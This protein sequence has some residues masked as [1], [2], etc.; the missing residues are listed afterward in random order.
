[1]GADNDVMRN[2]LT[3]LWDTFSYRG[4]K[5]NIETL[6]ANP[7]FPVNRQNETF[8]LIY[9][10]ANSNYE[11]YFDPKHLISE[12]VFFRYIENRKPWY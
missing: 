8:E 7:M 12:R 6:Q 9:W 5:R 11:V 4:L 2:L 10:L 1:M 3:Q